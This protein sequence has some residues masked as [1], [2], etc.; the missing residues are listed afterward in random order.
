[1][2]EDQVEGLTFV[3][4][5]CLIVGAVISL[6][7]SMAGV[8]SCCLLWKKEQVMKWMNRTNRAFVNISLLIAALWLAST[9]ISIIPFGALY[10]IMN[11]TVSIADSK[12]VNVLPILGILLGGVFVVFSILLTRRI[13]TNKAHFG[14]YGFTFH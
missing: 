12:T 1:M 8:L 6:I 14:D 2:D 9:I 5:F 11:C 7:G 4:L 3:G 10:L 13:W